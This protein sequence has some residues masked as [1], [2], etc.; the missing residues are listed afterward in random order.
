VL[1]VGAGSGYQ[2]AVLSLLARKVVA[3]ETQPAL[4]AAARE[5]LSRLGYSNVRIEE[6]DG[7][8]VAA[9]QLFGRA[10]N[11]GVR[12]HSRFRRCSGGS[13]AVGGAISRRR[14]LVIPVGG[15]ENQELLQI[16]ETPRAHHTTIALCLPFRSAAGTLWME[17]HR[18]RIAAGMIPPPELSII[19]PAYNEETRLPRTLTRIRDYFASRGMLRPTR[20]SDC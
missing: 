7:S 20:N 18:A 1:E 6:G 3:V 13:A 15:S 2:A 4:A 12:S 9:R 17:S 5:R 8:M 10:A 11:R 19:V 14:R 16:C